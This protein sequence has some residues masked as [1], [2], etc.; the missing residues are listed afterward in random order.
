MLLKFGLILC[1]TSLRAENSFSLAPEELKF[2]ERGAPWLKPGGQQ[3]VGFWDHLLDI[4]W[5]EMR[6]NVELLS[7]LSIYFGKY[8]KI[9][10]RSPANGKTDYSS[11]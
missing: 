7:I 11:G 3:C 6:G 2:R 4:A 10:T 1:A 8:C 9:L 5:G